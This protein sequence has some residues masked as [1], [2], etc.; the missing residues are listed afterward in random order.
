MK[1]TR[2]TTIGL[3]VLGFALVAWLV[4]TV[5]TYSREKKSGPVAK[6]DKHCPVCGRE[7]PL[8]SRTSGECP[9]CKV[10]EAANGGQG[11]RLGRNP[12]A[13]PIVPVLLLS[14]FCVLLGVHVWLALRKRSWR[15]KEEI[16]YITSCTKCGR[17][18]RYRPNQIGRAALCPLCRKPLI[19]PQPEPEPKRLWQLITKW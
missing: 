5:I 2:I 14:T 12:A 15:N 6:D 16:L 4:L 11:K 17:R 9:F 7:L 10:E 19:F 1:P 13:N 3:A 8:A 18:V